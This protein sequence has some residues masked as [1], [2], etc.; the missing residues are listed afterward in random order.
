MKAGALCVLLTLVILDSAC[1]SRP[2]TVGASRVGHAPASVTT[3]RLAERHPNAV[4]SDSVSLDSCAR[5]D[6]RARAQGRVFQPG[7]SI[8][9]T[10]PGSWSVTRAEQAIRFTIEVPSATDGMRLVEHPGGETIYSILG[11]PSCR[12]DCSLSVAFHKD[13]ACASAEGYVARQRSAYD[14]T[15]EES[16]AWAAASWRALTV[17]GRPGGIVEIPCG[18]CTSRSVY[19]ARADII[20]EIQLSVDDRDGYQP[21]LLCR[22]ARVAQTFQWAQ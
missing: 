11:F 3:A 2:D 22:L 13:S 19:T 18:D 16:A 20:A 12:Y 17:D 5:L 14:S 10:K 15:N 4:G 9:P 8:P 6:K 7:E 1:G 21:G